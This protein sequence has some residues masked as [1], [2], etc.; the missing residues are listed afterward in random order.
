MYIYG[1]NSLASAGRWGSRT[2]SLL[3][4]FPSSAYLS[5]LLRTQLPRAAHAE[6][7]RFISELTTFFLLQTSGKRETHTLRT[8]GGGARGVESRGGAEVRTGTY[9]GR[10]R[11]QENGSLCISSIL[12]MESRLPKYIRVHC[13]SSRLAGLFLALSQPSP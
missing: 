10:C 4:L 12:S 9:M 6:L 5:V 7:S 1:P 11:V 2:P 13:K 8:S 3:R